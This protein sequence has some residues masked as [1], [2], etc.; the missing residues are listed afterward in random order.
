VLRIAITPGTT[1]LTAALRYVLDGE[2]LLRGHER[3]TLYDLGPGRHYLVVTIAGPAGARAQR[4]FVVNAPAPVPAPAPVLTTSAPVAAAPATTASRPAPAPAPTVTTTPKP[5]P[6]T[7]IPQGPTAGDRDGDNNG[8]P[9]D[10][11]GNI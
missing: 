5:P 3:L 11:D 6:P 10:G 2:R 4:V 1:G 8:G 9:S 7:G